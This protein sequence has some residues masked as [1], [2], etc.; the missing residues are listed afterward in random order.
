MSAH[1]YSD[2]PTIGDGAGRVNRGGHYVEQPQLPDWESLLVEEAITRAERRYEDEQQRAK[3][4]E[5]ELRRQQAYH[6]LALVI[7][8]P[9]TSR[10]PDHPGQLSFFP[11]DPTLFDSSS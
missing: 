9:E 11:T 6:R 8:R 3:R 2:S 7:D 5:V 1:S 10:R 4:R